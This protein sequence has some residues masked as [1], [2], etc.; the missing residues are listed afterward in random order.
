MMKKLISGLVL[1]AMLACL[2]LPAAAAE[3]TALPMTVAEAVDGVSAYCTAAMQAAGTYSDWS[4]L[5]LARSGNLT[6]A[7]RQDYLASLAEKLRACGGVLD[8]SYYTQYSR[9]ILALTACGENARDFAGYDL[10]APLANYDQTVWQGVNGAAF[11]LSID[12]AKDSRFVRANGAWLVSALMSFRVQTETGLAFGHTNRTANY[13]ATEQA[14]YALAAYERF[15]AGQPALYTM[16][17]TTYGTHT[18]VRYRDTARHWAQPY[19]CA[20]T[21]QGL[22]NGV[23][24]D[25]F[26]P[27]GTLNRAMLA[28]VLWRA[29]G[30]PAADGGSFSDVPAG[31][32]YSTAVS[33]AQQSGI[34]QG[35]GEN[36]FAPMDSITREQLAVMLWRASGS[37]GST[38]S[39]A[40]FPDAG[41]CSDWASTAL[42][43]A[44]ERGILNGMDGRLAP[45]GTATRAQA[46][47]MLT[48]YLQ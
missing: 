20:V 43:W 16:T 40:A 42:A 47:A 11:A 23:G 1:L 34:V 38:Q 25:C 44:V 28:T 12:P 46:A 41:T 30:S 4:I 6:D 31:Q 32:W 26:D 35:V 18:C 2:V 37:P 15:L 27:E 29:S 14:G 8:K 48:R 45:G 9:T 24:G 5:Q 36:R 22:M 13:M 19:V 10:T 7:M 21:E 17:D 3:P 39:L 33:W